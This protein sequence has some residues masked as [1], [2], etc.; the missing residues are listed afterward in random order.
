MQKGVKMTKKPRLTAK[1]I[2]ELKAR[3][4]E[5]GE[6]GKTILSAQIPIVKVI[7][8]A[9]KLATKTKK[10]VKK[11]EPFSLVKDGD[12]DE[13]DTYKCGNCGAKLEGEVD[14]CPSCNVK[15]EWS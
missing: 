10:V 6:D 5:F 15:L 1:L 9:K 3:G 4:V 7:K 2:R 11:V 12:G 13:V 8:G 14:I